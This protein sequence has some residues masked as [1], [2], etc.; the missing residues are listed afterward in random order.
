MAGVSQSAVSRYLNGGS[1]SE[2]KR[3]RIQATIEETGYKP[4]VA[5]QMMRTGRQRQVGVLIPKVYSDS[6]AQIIEGF[7]RYIQKYQYGIVMGETGYD[8]EKE[9]SYLSLMQKSGA[10]GLLVMGTELTPKRIEAYRTA[11][12][13]LV[14]TGQNISGIPCVFHDDFHAVEELTSLVLERRSGQFAYIGVNESDPQTGKARREGML[15][16]CQKAG[17]DTG[18]IMIEYA[19]FNPRSGYDAMQRLLSKNSSIDGIVCATDTIAFG[20]MRALFESG[21]MPGKEVGIAGVGGSWFDVYSLTP[22]TTAH[23]YFKQC[24]QE[25]AKML[26]DRI[27][28]ISDDEY[29]PAM[30][31][32]LNYQIIERG[33]V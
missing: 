30:Q 18:D 20:A 5:A 29:K 8:E 15:S 33:S 32:R 26:L 13:P 11:K 25:A 22:L 23:F 27:E 24:G 9:L 4:A 14:V 6:V 12:A 21:R 7:T 2:E 1:L 31:L 3:K 19:S 16:A 17:R 10:A 28:A